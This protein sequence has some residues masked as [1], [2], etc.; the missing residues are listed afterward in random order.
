MYP[1]QGLIG[2]GLGA[3]KFG[4]PVL[5]QLG[6]QW[7]YYTGP[8]LTNKTLLT[9]GDWNTNLLM[10]N[11]TFNFYNIVNGFTNWSLPVTQF[12]YNN[13]LQV[14][15]LNVTIAAQAKLDIQYVNFNYMQDSI[16]L[17]NKTFKNLTTLITNQVKNLICNSSMFGG[18]CYLPG[19]C[20]D[21]INN[22]TPIS[23]SFGDFI[24]TIPVKSLLQ[25]DANS[26]NC[27]VLIKQSGDNFATLGQPWFRTF[28]TAFDA[29]TKQ[30]GI[31]LPMGSFGVM[32]N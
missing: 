1:V 11:T 7:S 24:Y 21:F 16:V 13:T 9:I 25:D 8:Y 30:I 22:F 10:P 5:Q 2:L 17:P 26:A 23:V 12:T 29:N 28:Y 32:T 6:G 19:V 15:L 4:N 18:A 31:G 14:P 27:K 3:T 20:S